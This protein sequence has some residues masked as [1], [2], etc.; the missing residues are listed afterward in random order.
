MATKYQ[1][2]NFGPLTQGELKKLG[3]G[4]ENGFKDADVNTICNKQTTAAPEFSGEAPTVNFGS[5]DF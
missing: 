1:T 3:K 2:G 4:F 5:S